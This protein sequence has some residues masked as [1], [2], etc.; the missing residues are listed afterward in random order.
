MARDEHQRQHVV[1]DGIGVEQDVHSGLPP[2][3][4]AGVQIARED[5]I[6]GIA[7]RPPP[8]G[9]DGPAPADGE[10]PS[11]R[12]GRHSIDGPGDER[13]GQR[14]LRDV[15]GQREIAGVP[16]EGADDAGGL[17][18]PHRLDGAPRLGRAHVMVVRESSGVRFYNWPDCSRQARSF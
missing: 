12:L 6:P 11:G 1:V 3:T 17:H 9:V 4:I 18:P 5:G 2:P 8:E 7:R 10:Q 14:L 16:G 13:L 15:L